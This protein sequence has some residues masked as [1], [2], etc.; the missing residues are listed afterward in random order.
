M[1]YLRGPLGALVSLG[2]LDPL[3]FLT[4]AAGKAAR[5]SVQVRFGEFVAPLAVGSRAVSR[6]RRFADIASPNVLSMGH[7]LKMLRIDTGAHLAQVVDLV[8][9]GNRAN[10]GEVGVDVGSLALL[11][12]RAVEIQTPV[13]VVFGY[14]PSPNPAAVPIGCVSRKSDLVRCAHYQIGSAVRP[15]APVMLHAKTA[16]LRRGVAFVN[17]AFHVSEPTHGCRHLNRIAA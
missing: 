16:R 4:L 5:A 2:A 9:I 1:T 12:T 14:R 15:S 17:C 3:A 8:A 11:R 10:T 6:R 13:P 7:G